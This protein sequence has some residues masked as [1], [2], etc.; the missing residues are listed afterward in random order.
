M[1]RILVKPLIWNLKGLPSKIILSRFRNTRHQCPEKEQIYWPLTLDRLFTIT[2]FDD[3]FT[4]RASN[5]Q[6]S[7]FHKSVWCNM[8][9]RSVWWEMLSGEITESV[10]RCNHSGSE[11]VSS[12][13]TPTS[14]ASVSAG[15]SME[16]FP[17][18]G[19]M[20]LFCLHSKRTGMLEEVISLFVGFTC[21]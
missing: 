3:I 11:P 10:S 18:F 12:W 17:Q 13:K 16:T 2:L 8:Q 6:A 20:V 7:K 14:T 9:H 15:E 4:K 1:S 21:L 19:E 5:D